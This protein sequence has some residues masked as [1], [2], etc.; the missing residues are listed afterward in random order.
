MER[1]NH[2]FYE[3]FLERV[4]QRREALERE[5]GRLFPGPT[6]LTL[7]VGCGHGH[8]LAAYAEAHPDEKCLGIDLINRRLER[9]FRKK[10]NRGLSNLDFLKAEGSE[11]LD[12]L[13]PEVTLARVFMIFS[14]PW[15]KKR[16]HKK[17]LI[18]ESFLSR[19][20]ERTEEGGE[21]C[22]RTDHEPYFE[23]TRV[24]IDSSSAW[25]LDPERLWPFEEP[26]FF[27]AILGQHDSLVA[28][29]RV[30]GTD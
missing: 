11:F 2:R 23:W 15:P 5:C 30:W 17:R 27:Q 4:G 14:D 1:G 3:E 25:N 13:P 24:L 7:E 9:A 20:A 28:V 10:E 21:L 16:H 18:Q 22:F 8:F 6:R 26:T 29:R 19:L 12:A